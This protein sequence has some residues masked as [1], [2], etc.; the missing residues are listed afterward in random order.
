MKKI[1]LLIL[2][3]LSVGLAFAQFPS[4]P[5]KPIMDLKTISS[6]LKKKSWFLNRR[7][8]ITAEF[9][10]PMFSHFTVG[11]EMELSKDISLETRIGV[12]FSNNAGGTSGDIR[13][14]A[15]GGGFVRTGVRF[16]RDFMPRGILSWLLSRNCEQNRH[17]FEGF[18]A[19]PEIIIGSFTEANPDNPNQ[20]RNTIASAILINIGE[21][22]CFAKRFLVGYEMGVGYA[23]SNEDMSKIGPNSTNQQN[24]NGTTNTYRPYGFYYSHFGAPNTNTPIAFSASFTLGVILG[25]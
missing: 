21:Q 5:E 23:F 11:H 19:K 1:I 24:A 4:I 9:F 15:K 12:I 8:A 10:A 7:H 16:Y 22:Y 20:R 2:L 18:Y 6:D 25:K 13:A 3:M 14:Y 17:V